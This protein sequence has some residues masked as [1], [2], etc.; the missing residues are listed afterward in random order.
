MPALSISMIRRRSEDDSSRIYSPG[1][2][3]V[4]EHRWERMMRRNG[5]LLIVLGVVL[6]LGA[7]V[8]AI[9][10]LTGGEDDGTPSAD[11]PRAQDVTVVQARRDVEAHTVLRQDDVEEIIVK[12]DTLTGDEV[13]SVGEVIG[14][15]YRT[16]L[17]EDQRL[18]RDGLEVS[19]IAQE[20]EVGTRAMSIPVDRNN[21]VA[22]LVRQDDRID[23]IFKVNLT[24]LRVTPTRPLELSDN[25]LLTLP[26]VEIEG[27]D[28]EAVPDGP[29]YPYAGDPGS[30]FAVLEADSGNPVV[31][32]V[33][34]NIR[35]L[36]VVQPS[37]SAQT[38]GTQTGDFLVLE[39]NAAQAELLHLMQT[40]GTFHIVLRGTE[41][42]VELTTTGLNMELLVTEY[43]FP[44]P[45]TITLPGP[46][47]Q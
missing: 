10:A 6:L 32:L 13:R 39:V 30:R 45:G 40:V 46:G 3:L 41:D 28:S 38:G 34:Q 19:G 14:L 36:R 17:V 15:A 8:L 4:G 20:L 16:D 21:L 44:M 42:D 22:G 31:R 23:I 11:S 7:V 29:V 35:I 18:L 9:F 24:L 27:Y 47:A 5:R 26:A 1:L 12:D 37:A 2:T 43:G 25:A 33:L